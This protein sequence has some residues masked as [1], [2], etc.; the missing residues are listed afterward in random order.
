MAKKMCQRA[1]EGYEKMYG[2]EHLWTLNSV[3]NLA[4]VLQNQR[5]HEMIEKIYRRAL[6]GYEKIRGAT[7][8]RTLE[9][10]SNLAS[11]LQ[12]QG[13]YEAAEEMRE[14]RRRWESRL[15]TD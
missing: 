13:K 10:A 2:V 14:K 8:F 3:N 4:S 12:N 5:K 9:T 11:V 6:A 1:L 15:P 7:D